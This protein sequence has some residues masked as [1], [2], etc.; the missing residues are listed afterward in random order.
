MGLGMLLKY[1]SSGKKI[2][3]LVLSA[4]SLAVAGGTGSGTLTYTYDGDGIISAS[5]SNTAIATVSVRDNTVAVTYVA[6]GSAT[7][8]VTASETSKYYSASAE[9]AVTCSRTAVTI[10]TLKST[11]VAWVGSSVSPGVNNL[12]TTLVTQGGTTSANSVGTWTVTWT[13][14]DTSKYCWSDGTVTQKSQNW[15]TYAGTNYT[16]YILWNSTLCP[17]T[18]SVC[19]PWTSFANSYTDIWKGTTTG[20]GTDSAPYRTPKLG[21]NFCTKKCMYYTYY[22]TT[23]SAWKQTGF[24]Q[25]L[26]NPGTYPIAGTTYTLT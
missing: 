2:P 22:S 18:V 26:Q 24:Y 25:V 6:V 3:S 23:Y 21:F 1:P 16:I 4:T 14:K 10:P 5:S 17:V 8:T 7:I 15:S 9:C 13:L 11:S 19:Q 12:N 20:K